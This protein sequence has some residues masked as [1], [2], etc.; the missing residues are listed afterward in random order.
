MKNNKTLDE[1]TF[2]RVKNLRPDEPSVDFTQKV[3]QSILSAVNP[4]YTLPRRYN[5]WLMGLIPIF[6]IGSWYLFA[7]LQWTGYIDTLWIAAAALLQPLIS[8]F[9]SLFIQ[10]ET[11]RIPPATLF[12]FVAIL[13]LLVAE[14]FLGRKRQLL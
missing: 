13:S 11:L 2:R 4:S 1:L 9:R 3:M 8:T 5:F 10:L 14:E 12:I 6:L 7:I